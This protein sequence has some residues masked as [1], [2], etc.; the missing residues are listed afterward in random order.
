[1]PVEHFG[2]DPDNL[3]IQYNPDETIKDPDL[4]G[5]PRKQNALN[6]LT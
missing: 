6:L 5:V 2:L 3:N 4:Y 1:M